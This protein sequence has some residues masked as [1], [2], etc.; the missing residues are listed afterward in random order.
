MSDEKQGYV[1]YSMLKLDKLRN[2]KDYVDCLMLELD[3][4]KKWYEQDT[5]GFGGNQNMLRIFEG[6]LTALTMINFDG[7][8]KELQDGINE[9]KEIM[10]ILRAQSSS[11][12]AGYTS[13]AVC[14]CYK[15]LSILINKL[16]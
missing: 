2:R 11:P 15:A 1:D 12:T 6:A 7:L 9:V 4:F 8:D 16:K 13:Q 5:R 10:L 14:V 3:H